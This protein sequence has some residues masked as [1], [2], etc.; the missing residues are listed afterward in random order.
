[1]NNLK[2]VLFVTIASII[3]LNTQAQVA[4]IDDKGVAI[5][6]YDVVSY[7]SGEAER[8]FA[9]YAAEH[10]NATYHFSSKANLA[11]FEKSPAQSSFQLTRK[12]MI[13]LMAS[14]I[15]FLTDHLMVNLL[16]L[17]NPGI[18]KLQNCLQ[19]P[20][21]TGKQLGVLTNC[22]SNT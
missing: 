22:K 21:K 13:L 20:I 15:C 2:F 16:I 14:Y 9:S 6:G 10:N 19:Q 7:F 18:Q 11:A 3:S 17:Y 4:P 5:G 8:G 1:M 12:P